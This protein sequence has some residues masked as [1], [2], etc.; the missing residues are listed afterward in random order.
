MMRTVMKN[1]VD[2]ISDLRKKYERADVFI[3]FLSGV[4]RTE[5]VGKSNLLSRFARDELY[6]NSKA[7]IGVEFETQMVEIDGKEVK[8]QVWDTAGQVRFRAVTSADYREAVRALVVYDISGRT[9]FEN[10]KRWLDEL[11]T[12]CDT[13]VA[14]MLVGNKCVLESIRDICFGFY[15]CVQGF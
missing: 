1:R 13:T 2:W 12:H 10:V 4:L 14:R 11:N 7:T 6:H 15:Q 9:T 5:Y 8:A 3:G